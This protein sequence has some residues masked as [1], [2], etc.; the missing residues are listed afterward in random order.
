MCPPLHVQS[1]KVDE[2]EVYILFC[3]VGRERHC[4]LYNAA[5]YSNTNTIHNVKWNIKTID[6]TK[7]ALCNYSAILH[8]RRVY[9]CNG[10][11]LRGIMNKNTRMF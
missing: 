3:L 7:M 5:Q 10:Q 9:Y 1:L 2:Q 8:I 6:I 4:H 11:G